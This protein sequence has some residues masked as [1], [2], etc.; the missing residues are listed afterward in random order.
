MSTIETT[1]AVYMSHA[2]SRVNHKAN[3]AIAQGC[4]MLSLLF[5]HILK[6]NH[7]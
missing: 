4:T 5:I 1:S 3:D 6:Q 7:Y 2:Q